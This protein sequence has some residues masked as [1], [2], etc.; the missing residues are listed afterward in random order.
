MIQNDLM[1]FIIENWAALLIAA[2]AF[3]KVVVN[4]TPTE[5]DNAV[6]GYVDLLINAITGDRRK[7]K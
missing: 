7:K 1:D 3:V 6:F 4:L 2:M 5:S